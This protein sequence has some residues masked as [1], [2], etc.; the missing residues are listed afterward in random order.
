[1]SKSNEEFNG[2]RKWL[3]IPENKLPPTHYDLLGVGIDEEDPEIIKAVVEQRKAFINTKRGTGH[4]T[5]VTEIL[6]RIGEAELTLLDPAMR[7]AYDRDLRL[8][9][10]R[11][12][13]RRVDPNAPR[14]NVESM[15]GRTVG[16]D[17][18]LVGQFGWIVGILTL[19]F[20]G[21]AVFSFNVLPWGKPA[22]QVAEAQAPAPVE[23][24]VVP[25]DKTNPVV[26]NA[27]VE[28]KKP[29]QEPKAVTQVEA[30]PAID[31]IDTGWL[32]SPFPG[33]KVG[34][35]TFTVSSDGVLICGPQRYA[36]G[37]N[38]DF[39][40]MKFKIEFKFPNNDAAGAIVVAAKE[41][42]ANG[43]LLPLG[44]RTTLGPTQNVGELE[45]P[46]ATFQ[47]EI[48][49]QKRNGKHIGRIRAAPIA[50][51]AWNTYE[52]EIDGDRNFKVTINDHLVN[53]FQKAESTSGKIFLL[54]LTTVVHF[55][56]PIVI[57][58][59]KETKLDFNKIQRPPAA[60]VVD[61]PPRENDPNRIVA[62]AVLKVG[63]SLGLLVGDR[64]VEV[65]KG[66]SLP[67]QQFR[68]AKIDLKDI[69]QV[70]DSELGDLCRSNGIED[71]K[72]LNLMGTSITD[73][74]FQHIA[75]IKR[76]AVLN[77]AGTR[78]TGAG[79]EQIKQLDNLQVLLCGGAPISDRY[80]VHLKSLTKLSLLGLID[81]PVTDAGLEHL[82]EMASL[83]NIRLT[84]NRV[85]NK[86]ILRLAKIKGLQ[87]LAVGRTKVTAAG[88][89]AF[90]KLLP[91]CVVQLQ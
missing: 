84:G 56:N 59:G 40:Q 4:D 6:Y 71:L 31:S 8:F 61:L 85:T 52:C 44:F 37:T 2:F 7:R 81:T 62:R 63:G 39:D 73:G 53:G 33:E 91:N 66:G 43:S 76:L 87:E 88:V 3:G 58:K 75:A 27:Q 23:P 22:E 36:I 79:F 13:G 5:A 77:I 80:L 67:N 74:A 86:G 45:L 21:M 68:V 16:E 64:F 24:K 65:Q 78:V 20:M 47:C 28:E 69:K 82:K 42:S 12:R 1:M 49:G 25:P 55:R 30:A 15:P 11:R 38:A 35:E 41:Q 26:A 60:P 89:T 51:A 29:T 46:S 54:P 17:G 10:K 18:G 90:K 48:F 14:T 9:E 34:P 50:T 19:A 83:R 57:V 70:V 72:E 32:L